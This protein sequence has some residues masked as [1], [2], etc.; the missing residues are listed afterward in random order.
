MPIAPALCTIPP[1]VGAQPAAI[2][3]VR[4]GWRGFDP[5]QVVCRLICNLALQWMEA[6]IK[7]LSR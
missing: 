3:K 4:F 6:G 1:T 2:T 7:M 5:G